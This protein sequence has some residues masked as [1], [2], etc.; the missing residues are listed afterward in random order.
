VILGLLGVIKKL[1]NNIQ[2]MWQRDGIGHRNYWL[3]RLMIK[4]LIFGQ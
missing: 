3:E 1:T 2:I 4:L